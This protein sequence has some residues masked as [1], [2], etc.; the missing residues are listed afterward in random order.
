MGA[1]RVSF[2]GE[3]TLKLGSA[4]LRSKPGRGR[5]GHCKQRKESV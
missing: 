4:K 1:R 3:D 5:V 2:L